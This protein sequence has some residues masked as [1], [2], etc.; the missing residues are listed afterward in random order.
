MAKK[1]KRRAAPE[2]P[3]G[4]PAAAGRVGVI[5]PDWWRRAPTPVTPAP[6]AYQGPGF[7]GWQTP[8]MSSPPRQYPTYLGMTNPY[9]GTTRYGVNAGNLY[10][11][12]YPGAPGQGTAVPMTGGVTPM[13]A[14]WNVGAGQPTNYTPQTFTPQQL[15]GGQN[16][17]LQQLTYAPRTPVEQALADV[18]QLAAGGQQAAGG[19]EGGG[20]GGGYP[21]PWAAIEGMPG[22]RRDWEEWS[23]STRGIPLQGYEIFRLSRN[24]A[25]WGQ[26]PN[27]GGG[28]GGGGQEAP[29]PPPEQQWNPPAS[30]W[31][32]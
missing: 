17:Y 1:G 19:G 7:G 21:V 18:G 8:F 30:Q 12:D 6:G 14:G 5:T 20:G 2:G 15:F 13:P 4:G 16:P 25:P 27:W 32:F 29:A 22:W 23:W 31:M 11:G 28:G 10:S 9:A 26:Q 24:V 3:G